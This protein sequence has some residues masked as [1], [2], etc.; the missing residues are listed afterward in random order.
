MEQNIVSMEINV[1]KVLFILSL[2]TI[3]LII[4]GYVF[5]SV[6]SWSK[7]QRLNIWSNGDDGSYDKYDDPFHV[8][9]D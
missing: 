2:A 7:G 8:E 9:E 1:F 3:A 4:I 5:I 6:I